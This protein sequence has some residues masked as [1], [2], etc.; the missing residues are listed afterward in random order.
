MI[1][2]LKTICFLNKIIKTFAQH[3]PKNYPVAI[4]Q[5]GTTANEKV[6]IQDA[7]QNKSTFGLGFDLTAQE[8][9]IIANSNLL[10]TGT[11]GIE[12]AKDTTFNNL[13]NSWLILFE[14]SPID[15]TSYRYNVTIR[16]L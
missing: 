10:K 8:Y 16:G 7:L 3:K 2:I 5:N 9:Y 15:S 6:I 4:I 13:D 14:F 11:L 1:R 12:H